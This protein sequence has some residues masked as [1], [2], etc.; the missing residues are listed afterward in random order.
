[1]IDFADLS[2]RVRVTRPWNV[3]T[4]CLTPFGLVFS[5]W[6]NGEEGRT[7]DVVP[8]RSSTKPVLA[9]TEFGQS[10]ADAGKA[11]ARLAKNIEARTIGPT[12]SERY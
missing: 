11:T 1:M 8:L 3:I 9:V 4:S 12:S 2:N 10:S 7:W 6:A 5:T